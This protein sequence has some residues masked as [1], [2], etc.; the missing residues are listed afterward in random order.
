MYLVVIGILAI[1][2]TME[3]P[4]YDIVSGPQ[5]VLPIV[6][7]ATILPAAVGAVVTRRVLGL[8]DRHPGQP[9]IGQAAYGRGMTIMQFLLGSA[10]ASVMLAT[11]WLPL[12]RRTPLVGE[13]PVVPGVIALV[14]FLLSIV[15]VWISVYPADRAIRQIAV[16]LYL[17]RSKPLHPVWPLGQYLQ[18]NFR[19]QVLFILVPMLLILA[20]HDVILIYYR[21]I[22]ELT[23]IR[24]AADMLLG[25]SALAVAVIAPEILRHVWVTQRLPDGPLRDRL[26]H[27]ARLLR[28][29]FRQVLVWRSGGMVVNAAVMGVIAPL[30]Y[31]LITDAMLEQME[32]A[33]IEAVFGHEAGH[34]K[35][36]HIAFFLMFAFVS[37]CAITIFSLRTQSMSQNPD[38]G[39]RA[40]YQILATLLGILLLA[41]WGLLFGWISRKFERQADVFGVRTLALT[42]LPCLQ[43]CHAHAANPRPARRP[44]PRAPLCATAAGIY[45]DA[46]YEVARLNGIRPAARSWRHSSIASRSLFLQ[47]L[48][49]DPARVRRFERTVLW[50]KIAIFVAAVIAGVWAAQDLELWSS[51]GRLGR[52]L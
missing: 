35:R 21:R 3:R 7:A 41:K 23:G 25:L 47:Q 2:L 6:A 11:D 31:V 26:L 22:F 34:V 4:L 16:E 48:A 42:G 50:I 27:L 38:P 12:C 37:G 43:P 17:F 30:R 36:H 24:Y 51:L 9:S 29:R 14:P 49:H 1:V 18:Y 10:H 20:A 46:L 8:L 28:L 32:D 52:T 13:W 40:E 44:G 5:L 15:L 33:K 39:V 45:A 19:H